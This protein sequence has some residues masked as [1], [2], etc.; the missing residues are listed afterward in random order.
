MY[1][2]YVENTTSKYTTIFQFHCYS[3]TFCSSQKETGYVAEVLFLVIVAAHLM[4]Y[5]KSEI[6]NRTPESQYFLW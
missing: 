3:Y 2:S 5:S 4:P 1:V 6:L